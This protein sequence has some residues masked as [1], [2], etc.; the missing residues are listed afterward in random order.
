MAAGRGA[1]LRTFFL[2]YTRYSFQTVFRE[3][4]KARK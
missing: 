3:W 2:N 1:S 4:Q